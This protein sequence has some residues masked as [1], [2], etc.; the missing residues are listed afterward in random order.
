MDAESVGTFPPAWFGRWSGQRVRGVFFPLPWSIRS[1]Q[2][3]EE[4]YLI[5]Q[6][7]DLNKSVYIFIQIL[8]I[9]TAVPNLRVLPVKRN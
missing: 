4:W 9:L 8:H 1:V 6:G 2:G 5:L 3:S 7:Q